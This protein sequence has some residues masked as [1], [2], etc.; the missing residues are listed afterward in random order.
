[1]KGEYAVV[2][3]LPGVAKSGSI[4]PAFAG[5]NNVGVLK[6]TSH[7]TLADRPDGSGSP[8]R[9]RRPTSS[10]RWASCRP[11]RTYGSRSAA[12]E[13]Y[14]KPFVAHPRRGHRVRPRLRPPGRQIDSSPGPA[15]D[16]PGGRQRQEGRGRGRR[17][18]RR[19]RWTTRSAPPDDAGDAR[20]PGELWIA[21]DRG[22]PA[23][24][25]APVAE[26]QQDTVTRPPRESK[27]PRGKKPPGSTSP[28]PSSILGGTARLPRLPA[29][30]DLLPAVHPGPGQRRRADHLPGVRELRRAVRGRRRSGG[31]CSPPSS[32]PPPA[33]SRRSPSAARSP[34]CSPGC[35]PCPGS[36]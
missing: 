36:R 13:P 4:A 33:S 16:V 12:K 10:T 9:R 8:P 35:G 17:R 32:S 29:R 21:G 1:M 15:D 14:V 23:A 27:L 7:R 18:T 26:P 31:C 28:P 30:P 34:C 25:R 22:S 6:S 2:L 20:W 24:G 19:R 3:P 11:T 5:G